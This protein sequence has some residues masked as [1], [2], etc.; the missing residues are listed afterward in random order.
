MVVIPFV[1]PKVDVLNDV[2]LVEYFPRKVNIPQGRIEI[3][4]AT[5][6][7][8]QPSRDLRDDF[9]QDGHA[10]TRDRMTSATKPAPMRLFNDA[11]LNRDIAAT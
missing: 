4:V 3:P 2:R 10:A 8:V 11:D 1:R 5:S 7:A 9:L 6:I